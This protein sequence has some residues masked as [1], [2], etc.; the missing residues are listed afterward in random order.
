MAGGVA[1]RLA[2]YGD[3]SAVT[4]VSKVGC[5]IEAASNATTK[6]IAMVTATATQTPLSSIMIT[7]HP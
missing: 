1:N 2:I 7:I 3:E 6:D 5:D 4:I